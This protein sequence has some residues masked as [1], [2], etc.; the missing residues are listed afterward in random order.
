MASPPALKAI[1]SLAG[2]GKLSSFVNVNGRQ[3]SALLTLFLTMAWRGAAQFGTLV[4]RC[5]RRSEA[6]CR[7]RWVGVAFQSHKRRRHDLQS[8]E[9][10]IGNRAYC[11]TGD[12]RHRRVAG[13][14]RTRTARPCSGFRGHAAATRMGRLLRA[15][16]CRVH[17]HHDGTALVRVKSGSTRRSNQ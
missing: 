8:L 15:A 6:Q 9:R 10:E 2:P 13:S 16:T 5:F 11:C 1:R 4:H 12:E 7:A 17:Q 3:T 14:R